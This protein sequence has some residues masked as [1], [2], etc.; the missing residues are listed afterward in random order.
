MN[1]DKHS[2]YEDSVVSRVRVEKDSP[3][4][5]NK[6]ISQLPEDFQNTVTVNVPNEKYPDVPSGQ[7][8]ENSRGNI[9]Y[10]HPYF[11]VIVTTYK[12]KE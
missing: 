11:P 10:Y 2:S 4:I 3:E 7:I 1:D 12:E 5:V 8:V 6:L 9:L